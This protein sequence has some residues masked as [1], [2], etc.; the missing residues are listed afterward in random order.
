MPATMRIVPPTTTLLR[1]CSRRLTTRSARFMDKPASHRWPPRSVLN[2]PH[3]CLPLRRVPSTPR[4]PAREDAPHDRTRGLAVRQRHIE[5]RILAV[6]M[7]LWPG[8]LKRRRLRP[9][10]ARPRSPHYLI[11]CQRFLP[12]ASSLLTTAYC[13]ASLTNVDDA[14]RHGA[15][16]LSAR[17]VNQPASSLCQ[18]STAPTR[19]GSAKGCCGSVVMCPPEDQSDMCLY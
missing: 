16:G 19:W 11:F 10:G 4:P 9:R 8:I 17:R 1:R 3:D 18:I 13:F 5:E 6:S 12:L 14:G 15:A 7:Q 2:D